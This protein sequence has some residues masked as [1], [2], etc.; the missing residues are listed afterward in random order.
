MCAQFAVTDAARTA[1]LDMAQLWLQLAQQAER[2][3][4]EADPAPF[5]GDQEP[6]GESPAVE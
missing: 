4:P 2:N 3:D 5:M 1:W 6:G